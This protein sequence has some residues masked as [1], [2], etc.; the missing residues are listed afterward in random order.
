MINTLYISYQSYDWSKFDR[1]DLI[2]LNHKNLAKIRDREDALDCYTT[3]EDLQI[4]INE[5]NN[6]V[7]CCNHVMLIGFDENFIQSVDQN[8]IL[9]YFALLSSLNRQVHKCLNPQCLD[10]LPLKTLNEKTDFKK[11]DKPALWVGGCSFS[12]GFTIS[13]EKKYAS[14]LSE[15]L[16]L[17]LVMLAKPGSSIAW[18]ADQWLR[19]DI[20]KDD[21]AIWGLTNVCRQEVFNVETASW[22]S[23]TI[24]SYLDTPTKYQYWNT[25]YFDSLTQ[26]VSCVKNILQ[27]ENYFQKIGVEYYFVNL[28]DSAYLPLIFRHH[29]RFLDL[30]VEYD[31]SNLQKFIDYGSDNQHPGVR[32]HEQYAKDI[33]DFM[34]LKRSRTTQGSD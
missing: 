24:A 20:N 34:Q 19:S 10:I 26:A 3:I 15:R 8:N 18:Q 12:A 28:M 31:K 27:V 14:L 22:Q 23:L 11:N 5:I 13:P 21:V 17:P 32:Q 4:K 2:F 7:G 33:Y 25:D 30:T 16:G 29:S 1:K 9:L 6:L